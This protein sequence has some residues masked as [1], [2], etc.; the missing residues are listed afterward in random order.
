ML[1]SRPKGLKIGSLPQ[2]G[3]SPWEL[4]EWKI[5]NTQL[6]Y[7]SVLV[8]IGTITVRQQSFLKT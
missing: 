1:G 4:V 7:Y 3:L 8:I 5:E 2:W 6:T